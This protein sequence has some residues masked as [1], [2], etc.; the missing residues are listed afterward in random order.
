MELYNFTRKIRTS[1]K[2]A[3]T[4]VEFLLLLGALVFSH[5]RVSRGTVLGAVQVEV[6]TSRC[7]AVGVVTKLGKM[8]SI[9]I[10][11]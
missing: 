6:G 9:I 3:V 8:K 5:L 10:K 1:V 2:M 4:L 11:K 7:A